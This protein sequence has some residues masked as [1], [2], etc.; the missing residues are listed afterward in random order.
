MRI[1]DWSSDVCSSD[2][3]DRRR[4]EADTPVSDV[5][6]LSHDLE[7]VGNAALSSVSAGDWEGFERYEAARLQLVMSLGALAREEARREAVV[8]A[9]YRAADQGRT[10]ATD[11]EAAGLGH[12]PRPGAARRQDRAAR[13]R[14][15]LN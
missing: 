9:L 3:G 5:A 15:S 7:T 4:L 8:T 13:A 10:L 12:N 14:A 1:S 6:T 11:V 2:L